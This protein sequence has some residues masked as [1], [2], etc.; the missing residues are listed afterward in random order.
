M[1]YCHFKWWQWQLCWQPHYCFSS[2]TVPFIYCLSRAWGGGSS[3]PPEIKK[4]GELLYKVTFCFKRNAGRGGADKPGKV[5]QTN[6]FWEMLTLHFVHS[7]LEKFDTVLCQHFSEDIF[8]PEEYSEL[9]CFLRVT[10]DIQ[11]CILFQ[12]LKIQLL[13]FETCM[14]YEKEQSCVQRHK[15]GE[16]G[17]VL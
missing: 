10:P 6:H 13:P 7:I 4:F 16:A 9:C 15:K 8:F 12:M 2:S 3:Q 1:V 11:Y 14:K 17:A 5:S